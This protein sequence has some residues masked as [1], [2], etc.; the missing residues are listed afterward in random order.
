[1]ADI[2]SADRRTLKALLGGRVPARI[3]RGAL[4]APVHGAFV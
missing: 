1:M 2:A 3:A 4:I